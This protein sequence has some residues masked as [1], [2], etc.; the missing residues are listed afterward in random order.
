MWAKR[1]LRIR[2]AGVLPE[3]RGYVCISARHWQLIAATH[4]MGG[5]SSAPF[6]LHVFGIPAMQMPMN[7]PTVFTGDFA[8]GVEFYDAFHAGDFGN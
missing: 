6:P 1:H 4:E 5:D 8:Q 2:S 3:R 7:N